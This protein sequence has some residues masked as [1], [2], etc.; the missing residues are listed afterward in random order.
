[1]S[2]NTEIP[3]STPLWHSDPA[4]NLSVRLSG[5]TIYHPLR[6]E[7]PAVIAKPMNH[8]FHR[9]NVPLT[10][11]IAAV[12]LCH[13]VARAVFEILAGHRSLWQLN[14]AVE[15][16]CIEKL[17]SQQLIETRALSLPPAP[18]TS[19]GCVRTIRMELTASGAYEC[20]AVLAFK[21]RVRAV[22]LKI[23]LWHGRWQV[24]ELEV[25]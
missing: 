19:H 7:S 13:A 25:L 20:A 12:H 23:E 1:M 15:P 8:I 6:H 4:T 10:S 17:R 18:G 21:H 16:R 22:A 11:R 2:L 9:A 5:G 3:H 24:T 14:F